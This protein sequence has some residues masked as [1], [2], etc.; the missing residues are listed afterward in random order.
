MEFTFNK[1]KVSPFVQNQIEDTPTRSY[2]GASYWCK[3]ISQTNEK[4]DF[5]R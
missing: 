3:V 4:H 1:V 2:L 5:N